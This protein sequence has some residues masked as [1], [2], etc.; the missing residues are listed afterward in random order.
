MFMTDVHDLFPVG[1]R[2]SS[3]IFSLC[4]LPRVDAM[5]VESGL[6]FLVYEPCSGIMLSGRE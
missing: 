1:L 4:Q 5:A 2:Q 6:V 3:G